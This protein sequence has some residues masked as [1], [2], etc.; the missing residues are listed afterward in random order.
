M[1]IEIVA[2]ITVSKVLFAVFTLISVVD[3]MQLTEVICRCGCLSEA[4]CLHSH[5]GLG[6]GQSAIS[7]KQ[8]Q[9]PRQRLHANNQV[10]TNKLFTR[11]HNNEHAGLKLLL[12][13]FCCSSCIRKE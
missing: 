13:F 12:L 2:Y 4:L 1:V 10:S 5:V 11:T 9:H 8:L 3:A 6:T 7:T